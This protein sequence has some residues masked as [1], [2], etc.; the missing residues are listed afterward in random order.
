MSVLKDEHQYFVSHEAELASSFPDQWVAISGSTVV[1]HGA[2][3]EAYKDLID[4][5]PV[6]LD[7]VLVARPGSTGI[8]LFFKEEGEDHHRGV[9]YEPELERLQESENKIQHTESQP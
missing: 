3:F 7:S 5:P 9:I 8:M 4:E 2:D 6:P 1:D